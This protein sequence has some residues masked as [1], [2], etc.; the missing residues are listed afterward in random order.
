MGH[1]GYVMAS[2]VGTGPEVHSFKHEIFHFR[3][4]LGPLK[5]LV[6]ISA[7]A[8]VLS[9]LGRVLF[10]LNGPRPRLGPQACDAPSQS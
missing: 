9:D 10:G 2:Q 6:G 7:L 5:F 3:P 4:I 1:V 8:L